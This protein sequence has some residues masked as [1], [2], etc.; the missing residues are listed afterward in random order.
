MNDL[1]LGSR[2]HKAVLAS[3]GRDLCKAFGEVISRRREALG[4]SLEAVATK[5]ELKEAGLGFVESGVGRPS[6]D[7]LC[8]VAYALGVT[9]ADLIAESEEVAEII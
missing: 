9:A 1:S 6:L 4:L 2:F 8:R 3:E 5:A 7:T